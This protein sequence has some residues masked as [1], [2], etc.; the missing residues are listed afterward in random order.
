MGCGCGKSVRVRD[1]PS[2]AQ[3]KET[4]PDEHDTDD[5]DRKDVTTVATAVV[6]EKKAESHETAAAP[7]E[8]IVTPP[9]PPEKSGV[10]L[11]DIEALRD[12]HDEWLNTVSTDYS[13][14]PRRPTMYQVV[15][16][17]I[18]PKTASRQ[19]AFA[20]LFEERAPDVFVSHWW[21]E[22]FVLFV[23]ALRKFALVPAKNEGS[24]PRQE[25]MED[26]KEEADGRDD[27]E[28]SY[29][30]LFALT[31]PALQDVVYWVCSLA[32][33][34]W[35]V[36]LGA[37]L[38]DSPFERALVHENC[39]YVVMVMDPEVTPLSRIWCL[40]EVLR[41]H[42][43][44]KKFHI[45][46]ENGVLT[47]GSK[48]PHGKQREDL[49]NM[50]VKVLD[51]NAQE[52]RASKEQDRLQI[53]MAIREVVGVDQFNIHVKS[54]LLKAFKLRGGNQ[55]MAD[56]HELMPAM[57]KVQT[58]HNSFVSFETRS[59]IHVLAESGTL[60]EVT[61]ALQDVC[62][63]S[64]D[65]PSDSETQTSAEVVHSISEKL[66][67]RS[68]IGQ[69]PLHLAVAFNPDVQVV[70]ALLA[71]RADMG[72][73]D[74]RGLSPLGAGA[75]TGRPQ[76]L[77]VLIE[78]RADVT[79]EKDMSMSEPTHP[80]IAA[81]ISSNQEAV[82]VLL[83]A[84]AVAEST[85]L[86]ACSI[87]GGGAILN[88]LLDARADPNQVPSTRVPGN[89]LAMAAQVNNSEVVEGLLNARADVN[90]AGA[91]SGKTPLMMAAAGGNA[92]LVGLLLSNRADPWARDKDGYDP[93]TV[94]C[95]GGFVDVVEMLLNVGASVNKPFDDG[96]YPIHLAAMWGRPKMIK[97]LA[98]K[99]AEVNV[100]WED[101]GDTPLMSAVEWG[102][103]E[104]IRVLVSLKADLHKKNLEGNTALAVAKEKNFR[105]TTRLLNQFMIREA[106]TGDPKAWD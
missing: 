42:A 64:P 80:L 104:A 75:L 81:T 13:E 69:T 73:F 22:E 70:A 92:D 89:A 18:R 100:V 35:K 34:Q 40:Y 103:N 36:D 15:E 38:Q 3:S 33:R 19:C 48:E 6:P 12:G 83:D 24:M 5:G 1:A 49:L 102:Y 39:K 68:T 82:Q 21:G 37:T 44:K 66:A 60:Q 28:V 58:L 97:F 14:V 67:V 101:Y 45:A 25:E 23:S 50:C 90:H 57:V 91:V 20:E 31:D 79:S 105:A 94:A 26:V 98:D 106:A 71:A 51:I 30:D 32:N 29:D 86:M 93:L 8:P 61:A 77:K 84:G 47:Y 96:R 16:H 76:V 41:A 95:G 43:L 9:R 54:L 85:S 55:L 63:A 46:T 78:N 11:A 99:G 87:F 56:A 74:E 88:I 17:L 65:P 27:A 59:R 62:Q 2:D 7:V 52:A 53:L 4:S 10:R 72:V